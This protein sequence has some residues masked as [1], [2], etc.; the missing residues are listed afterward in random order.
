MKKINYVFPLL[1]LLSAPAFADNA[2]DH[3]L[4]VKNGCTAC[5]ASETKIVGPSFVSVA[6]KYKDDSEASKKLHK[7]IKEGGKGVWG[8][9][10]MPAHEEIS[11]SDLNTLVAWALRGGPQK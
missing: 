9:I 11:D 3:A 10:P 5:H 4:A 8:R 7:K 6:E 1:A 2:S